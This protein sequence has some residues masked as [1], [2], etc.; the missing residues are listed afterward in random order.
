[1]FLAA[2]ALAIG[3]T[4]PTAAR[5]DGA[6]S[7]ERA[8]VLLEMQC[9]MGP[10]QPGSAGHRAL[11]DAIEAHADSLGL[12]FTRLCFDQTDPWGGDTLSL[13]NL[14]ISCAGGDGPPLWLGAHYD[15]RPGCDMEDDPELAARPLI[16][17]NDGASGV[18]VLLHLAELLAAAPPPRPV[19]L[20]FFDGEDSGRPGE[21]LSYCLGSQHLAAHWEDFGSPLAGPRPE[22]LIVIDMVGERGLEIP[23]E[24]LSL[25]AAGPWLEAMFRRAAELG[26]T[27]F[28]PEPGRPVFDDHMPFVQRGLR[29]VDLID[30]DFPQWHTVGDVP[31][32]CDPRS[33][34]QVGRLLADIV[35][36]PLE[37]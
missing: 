20:I 18:A 3:T 32:V 37:P 31:A 28:R 22:G 16:G 25:R 17:A 30:F 36:R 34:E 19:S 15:T 11:Q 27:A 14:V 1:M 7:G 21:T 8:M 35:H 33:L 26:L 29:A 9:E 23:Y 6:F 12:R 10:R 13:C 4:G 5:A 2:I 24:P